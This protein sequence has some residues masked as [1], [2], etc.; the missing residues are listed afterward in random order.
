MEIDPDELA[1][2]Q[3]RAASVCPTRVFKASQRVGRETRFA[4]S[5]FA[6]LL[7]SEELAFVRGRDMVNGG[8]GW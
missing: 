8:R 6:V 1:E 3:A 5:S 2:H 7:S 4:D